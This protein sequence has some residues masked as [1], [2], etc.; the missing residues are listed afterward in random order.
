MKIKEQGKKTE[1]REEYFKLLGALMIILIIGMLISLLFSCTHHVYVHHEQEVIHDTLMVD[2]DT[3]IIN[4]T[5]T[6]VRW[7]PSIKVDTNTHRFHGD[8]LKRVWVQMSE[9]GEWKQFIYKE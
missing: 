5:D 3:T 8:T 6:L 4:I 9:N 2:C 1:G 7:E